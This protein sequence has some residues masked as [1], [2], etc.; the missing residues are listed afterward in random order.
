M[1]RTRAIEAMLPY[2]VLRDDREKA[3]YGWEWV[4]ANT[5]DGRPLCAGTRIK[6]L[7]TGDYTLA[8][9]ESIL[10]IER[11]GA[12]TEFVGNMVDPAFENELVRMAQFRHP[13]VILEFGMTHLMTWP[14]SSRLPPYKR[15]KLPLAREGAALSRFVELRLKYPHVHFEF[16]EFYGKE[17]AES[18]FKRVIETYASQNAPPE[19]P[20]SAPCRKASK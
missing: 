18:L 11:K 2:T 20:K 5:W 12:V 15:M 4:A 6:R 16:A 1:R 14:D 17:V 10:C 19:P 3:G 8:G 7:P 9:L 13:W